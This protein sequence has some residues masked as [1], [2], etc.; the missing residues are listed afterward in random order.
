MTINP[1]I[2]N[3]QV[4]NKEG[5]SLSCPN[6]LQEAIQT[7]IAK[8][9]GKLLNAEGFL[10]LIPDFD[11][12]ED[13]KLR[14]HLTKDGITI[15]LL[16]RDLKDSKTASSYAENDPAITEAIKIRKEKIITKVDSLFKEPPSLGLSTRLGSEK[17]RP[18]FIPSQPSQGEK[19]PFKIGFDA[20]VSNPQIQQLHAKIEGLQDQL[21]KKNPHSEE[22]QI[23]KE[24][25]QLLSQAIHNLSI[26]QEN[27]TYP[28]TEEYALIDKLVGNQ[29]DVCRE[30]LDLL[31]RN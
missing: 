16:E 31:S 27:I 10:A 21:N 7:G 26:S 11:P 24:Q 18:L 28:H 17:I 5:Y 3:L 20:T 30:L 9:V 8:K 6:D 12:T 19:I 13:T 1:N 22:L 14:I 15:Q 4:F 29:R 25:L 2:S 23:I